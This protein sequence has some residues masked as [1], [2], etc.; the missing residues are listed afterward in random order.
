[1]IIIVKILSFFCTCNGI[2]DVGKHALFLLQY[3]ALIIFSIFISRYSIMT[4]E[5]KQELH[6]ALVQINK[7]LDTKLKLVN[8]SLKVLRQIDSA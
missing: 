1:M 3:F 8:D 4:P 6:H 2:F 7:K 5:Y